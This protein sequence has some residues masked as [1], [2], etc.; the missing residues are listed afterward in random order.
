MRKIIMHWTGGSHTPNPIDLKAY[1]FVIDGKGK[2]VN[3]VFPPEANLVPV[4]GK[5]AA[6]CFNCNSGSIGVALAAMLDAKE[7]PFS[8]GKFPITKS[9]VSALINFVA[10]LCD[11]YGIPVTPETVLTHAEVEKTLGVKQKNKWDIVY[12][13]ELGKTSAKVVG[14]Y[15]RQKIKEKRKK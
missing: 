9:Q 5:Y 3:G 8:A 2:V 7:V 13:P 1:H 15:L 6:H 12:L 4:P 14:D 11:K 10:A